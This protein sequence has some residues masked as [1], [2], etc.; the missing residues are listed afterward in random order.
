MKNLILILSVVTSLSMLFG[1]NKEPLP[2]PPPPEYPK[3]ILNSISSKFVFDNYN[4]PVQIYL[5]ES[6]KTNKNLPIIYV[7]DGG[8][9]FEKVISIINNQDFTINTIVVAVGDFVTKEEWQRRWIDLRPESHC[10]PNGKH[11]DFYNF[12]TQE[13]VPYIDLNYKNDHDSRSL[14]GHSSAGLFTLVSM[15]L[16]DSENVVFQNFIA[17]DPELGCD[18]IYF[19]EM[20]H[21]YDFSEGA[22]KFKFYLALSGWGTIDAVRQFAADIEEKEYAWLT[23]KYEEFLDESHMGV[24]E[25]SF[26]SGLKF[27]FGN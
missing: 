21:D 3:R 6:Y 13:L 14:M 26:E 27:L 17:S 12:I 10:N 24:V 9:N 18:P 20:L 22:K 1:C 4:Y 25:P 8:I 15:F 7:L 11:L 2:P 23:F 19:A 16:E 5:P